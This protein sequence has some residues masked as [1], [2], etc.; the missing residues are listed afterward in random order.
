MSC[1]MVTQS[2]YYH[3]DSL[4]EEIIKYYTDPIELENDTPLR[5]YRKSRIISPAVKY[6]ESTD[7]SV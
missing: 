5:N 6:A 2:P 4:Y 7:H 3:P 1:L